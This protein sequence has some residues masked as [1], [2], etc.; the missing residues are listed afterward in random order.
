MNGNDPLVTYGCF[1]PGHNEEIKYFEECRVYTV[2]IESSLACQQGCLYC[3]ASSEDAPMKELSSEDIYAILDSAA[4]MDVRA[5]DWLGGDPLLRKDWYE[6][7]KYAVDKGLKNNIWTSG[8]P[9][10]DIEVAAKAVEISDG[11]FI[12]VHLDS[13]DREIY[14]KLHTGNPE[15]KMDA[16]LE[17]VDNVQS[18]GK[19]PENM[20]NCITF[21]KP[22]ADEDVKNTIRYFF[23]EKGMRTCLT[24]LSIVGLAKEHADWVPDLKEIREACET[25]DKDNYPD[26]RLSMG[27]M[28]TNKF[29]CGGIICVT[30]DGDVTPCSVIRKGY[31]NIHDSSLENIVDRSRNELLFTHIRDPGNMSGHCRTCKNNSVCWGC[32]ATAYYET[33]DILAPDPRCWNNPANIGVDM[34]EKNS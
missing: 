3:Y 11:G 1:H 28:D 13:L 9:L 27:S 16:I 26:S 12:S 18:L 2:Q 20:I 14:R 10:M 6:L 5:I 4:S 8:M 34:F 30:V 32:R 17:G 25:R 19:K 24:Q 15:R 22:V 23:R 33:G 31:G 21:T 29:Y 7:M